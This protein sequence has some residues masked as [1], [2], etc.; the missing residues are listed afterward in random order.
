MER[1]NKPGV[2]GRFLFFLGRGGGLR[3]SLGLGFWGEGSGG[4]GGRGEDKEKGSL[5]SICM[6]GCGLYWGRSRREHQSFQLSTYQ[7]VQ[8]TKQRKEVFFSRGKSQIQ[9]F[10]MLLPKKT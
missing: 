7:T 8:A 1:N 3:L 6:V 10:W 9:F 2:P 5:E 4:K